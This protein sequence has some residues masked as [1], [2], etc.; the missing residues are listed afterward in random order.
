VGERIDHA[1]ANQQIIRAEELRELIS[2]SQEEFFNML[3]IM[4]QSEQDIYFSK[5]TAGALK[6]AIVSTEDDLVDKDVQVEDNQ[7]EEKYNQAPEDIMANYQRQ[8]GQA[9]RAYQRKKKDHNEALKLEKFMQRAGPVMENVV[10]EIEQDSFMANREKAQ[11]K[12][13]VEAKSTLTFPK[14]VLTLFTQN[15]VAAKLLKV[16]ALHMFESSPQSKCAVAYQVEKA[17]GEQETIVIVFSTT[18]N[19]VL[20]L[21]RSEEEVCQMCTPG[22]D[23]VLICG[24]IY[25]SVQLYDL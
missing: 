21:L 13:A 1:A 14:E 6:T 9:G 8:N 25:G 7:Q 22:D 4:P 16:T 23:N 20:R 11:K 24:T 15:R 17:D 12:G 18:A 19:Q 3:D 2:F 10:Q 5:I